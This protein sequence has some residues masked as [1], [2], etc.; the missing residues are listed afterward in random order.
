MTPVA[1]ARAPR[2]SS[3]ECLQPGLYRVCDN[4]HHCREVYGLWAARELVLESEFH[5][6]PIDAV[7]LS[8]HV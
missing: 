1:V 8:Q 6:L 3:T 7:T 5:Q 2:G 4:D